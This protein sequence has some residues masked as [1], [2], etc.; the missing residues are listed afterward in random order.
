MTM[1]LRR[2]VFVVLGA[3]AGVL[4][5]TAAP[6]QAQQFD[7][8]LRSPQLTSPARLKSELRQ[9]VDQLAS[10]SPAER[11]RIAGVK[12]VRANLHWKLNRMVQSGREL[13]DLSE[14]GITKRD[15]S[16]YF[17]VGMPQWEIWTHKLSLLQDPEIF[18]VHAQRLR[19]RGFREQDIARL[20][21]YVS[22][23]DL[24]RS[25]LKAEKSLAQSI[26][27]EYSQPQRSQSSPSQQLQPAITAEDAESFVYQLELARER[28]ETTWAADLL[29]RLDNQHQRILESY[30]RELGGFAAFQPESDLSGTSAAIAEQLISGRYE[31][32]IA[33]KEQ[34]HLR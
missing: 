22:Q 17:D 3:F 29:Q 4:L 30:Y 5:I 27:A 8:Q 16:Y 28:A 12:G 24:E 14:F 34:E 21:E 26:A 31:Q 13:P 33:Q 1:S 7:K 6:S 20:K 10:V 2:L 25:V 9:N 18:E 19:E 15:G 32:Q 11:V 23:N